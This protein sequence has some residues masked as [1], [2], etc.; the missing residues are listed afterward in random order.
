MPDPT[1]L[2]L[3]TPFGVGDVNCYVFPGEELTLVDPGPD[4][5]PAYDALVDGL[6]ELGFE[7]SEVEHVLVTHPHLDHFG[8]ISRLYEESGCLVHIHEDSLPVVEDFDAYYHRE[9]RYFRIFLKEM[10]MPAN[11][12]GAVV[13]LPSSYTNLGP[14]VPSRALR[15][16]QDGDSIEAEVDFTCVE[17]P[18]HAVGSMS[19]QVDDVLL[20]GDHLMDHITPNPTLQ[21]PEDGDRPR[22]LHQYLESMRELREHGY[23]RCLPGHG[24]EVEDPET[25]IEYTLDHHEDRKQKLHSMVEDEAMTAY[26]LMH[27]MWDDLPSTEYFFG[28]SEVIGHMDLLEME[29]QVEL[30][31]DELRTYHPS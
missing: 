27:E 17:T 23:T 2:Q 21:L 20:S 5:E 13:E 28:M 26:E 7:V 18:G 16:Y 24:P 22:T 25:R 11:E 30:K 6:D 12:A 29:D 3:P 15:P 10:G 31:G 19:F 9:K 1:K 4:T 8:I 14:P